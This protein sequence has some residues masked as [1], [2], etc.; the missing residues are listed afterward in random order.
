M[1]FVCIIKRTFQCAGGSSN[2]QFA[3]SRQPLLK[4]DCCWSDAP[5][6]NFGTSIANS[7][8]DEWTMCYDAQTK[9]Y[10]PRITCE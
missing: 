5:R 8:V 2:K 1:H 10:K 9:P 6:A 3:I 7:E 4:T